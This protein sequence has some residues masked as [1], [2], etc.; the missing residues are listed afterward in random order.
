[1]SLF[2]FIGRGLVLAIWIALRLLPVAALVLAI[3]LAMIFATQN[4]YVVVMVSFAF[5]VFGTTFLYLN[6][7]RAGLMA[8]K[9]TSPPT[10]NGLMM[11][12]IKLLFVHFLAQLLVLILLYALLTTVFQY[13]LLPAMVPGWNEQVADIFGSDSAVGF[14]A[15]LGLLGDPFSDVFGANAMIA[16]GLI[17]YVLATLLSGICV[18]IFGV[19]M[20]GVGANAVQRGPNHDLVFGLG[21]S[22]LSILALYFVGVTL[23]S[24]AMMAA[25]PMWLGML[26]ES[27]G[28]LTFFIAALVAI[29]AASYYM[30]C[31]PF[32]AMALAYEQATENRRREIKLEQ[33]PI[34]SPEDFQEHQASVRSLRQQRQSGSAARSVYVPERQRHSSGAGDSEDE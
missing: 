23:P 3:F 9:V 12:T 17:F 11:G 24:A 1:M 10:A 26:S 4:Y 25:Y 14:L 21:N 2:A 29:C 22:F 33:A 7:I 5:G 16:P 31:I 27:A 20:A 19:P 15:T 6:G 13:L 34:S 18:A 32:A 8:R 28:N 30:Y